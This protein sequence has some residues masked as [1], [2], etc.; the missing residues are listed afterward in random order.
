MHSAG[1]RDRRSDKA[2]PAEFFTHR[3]ASIG[4]EQIVPGKRVC[5]SGQQTLHRGFKR[6]YR[7]REHASG[8]VRG[9]LLGPGDRVDDDRSADGMAQ[10]A[11]QPFSRAE[12]R[13]GQ[14]ETCRV[15]RLFRLHQVGG[16]LP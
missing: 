7:P 8:E 11:E 10:A 2:A 12:G 3:T 5:A 6:Q 1:N 16:H 14:P 13:C 4:R 9:L 15:A